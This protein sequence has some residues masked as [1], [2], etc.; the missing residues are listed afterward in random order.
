M[1]CV[2]ILGYLF[3]LSEHPT[4]FDINCS[5]YVEELSNIMTVEK[6]ELI[7]WETSPGM[8]TQ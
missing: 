6:L 8:L 1:V 2:S 4:V 5:C 7:R 3:Q